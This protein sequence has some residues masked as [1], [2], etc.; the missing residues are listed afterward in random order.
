M[1][2]WAVF[3][4][5][6]LSISPYSSNHPSGYT[7]VCYA[8]LF[9]HCDAHLSAAAVTAYWY[10]S[11]RSAGQW[12]GIPT[13][14]LIIPYFTHD[15]EESENQLVCTAMRRR[16]AHHNGLAIERLQSELFEGV[17]R[18]TIYR[19]TVATTRLVSPKCLLNAVGMP[20]I[21]LTADITER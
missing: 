21:P 4:A 15:E 17:D 16:Y 7:A 8:E 18:H 14:M 19:N 2:W 5:G 13:S 10:C 6:I 3:G 1:R 20:I 12:P 11:I 9:L